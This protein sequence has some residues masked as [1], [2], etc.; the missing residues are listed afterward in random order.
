MVEAAD[1]SGKLLR[2]IENYRYFEPYRRARQ[3]IE[4]GDIGEPISM[5]VKSVSGTGGWDVP[6]SA[7]E[8][9]SDPALAGEGSV[10]FDHG[11]HIWAVAM[12]LLGAVESVFAFVG[13]TRP[14]DHFEVQPGSALDS[15]AMISWKYPGLEM[16]GSCEVVHS[17]ELVVPSSYYPIDLWFEVTGRQGVVTVNYGP[18]G[19]ML[20]RPAVD[21][22]RDGIVTPYPDGDADYLTSFSSAVGDFVD[23]VLDGRQSALTGREAREV[24]R[25]SLA[26]LRSGKERREVRLG[27]VTA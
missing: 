27:E 20:D 7:Q 10:L 21:V 24:L 13:Q 18:N 9:R 16:Y 2:V 5:R 4:A 6:D 25:F 19:R 26:I 1:R 11:H 23:A 22:Y 3:V 8:W 15:P 14:T 12:H 17:E